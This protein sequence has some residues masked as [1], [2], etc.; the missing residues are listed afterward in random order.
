M[1]CE[2]KMYGEEMI[3]AVMFAIY[4]IA[5]IPE[6]KSLLQ[7]SHLCNCLNCKNN[8]EDHFFTLQL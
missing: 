8:Y 3:P 5:K 4:A 1:N 2:W 6:T 7:G